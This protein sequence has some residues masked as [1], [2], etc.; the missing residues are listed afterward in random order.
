MWI[1]CM[2]AFMTLMPLLLLM[3]VVSEVHLSPPP[4]RITDD[5]VKITKVLDAKSFGLNRN[6]DIW[7]SETEQRSK[8]G[9]FGDGAA[10]DEDAV[11]RDGD[12][13]NENGSH[14]KNYTEKRSKGLLCFKLE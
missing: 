13:F 5:G 12:F 1:E 14:K 11:I 2:L 7:G 10:R 4:Q 8:R 6:Y 9:F 3:N